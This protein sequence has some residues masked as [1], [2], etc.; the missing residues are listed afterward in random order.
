M[1]RL[2]GAAAGADRHSIPWDSSSAMS[3]AFSA[4]SV[5]KWS[6]SDIVGKQRGLTTHAGASTSPGIG[7]ALVPTCRISLNKIARF[8]SHPPCSRA[9]SSHSSRGPA[10]VLLPGNW[11]RLALH[12][13]AFPTDNSSFVRSRLIL[14]TVAL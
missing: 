13:F 3:R 8:M 9:R 2:L 10:K 4:R 14:N 12:A 5:V 1:A 7:L 11:G 6:R